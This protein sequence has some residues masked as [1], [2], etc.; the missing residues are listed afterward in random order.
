[1]RKTKYIYVII[2][3]ILITCNSNLFCQTYTI[4]GRVYT[5]ENTPLEYFHVIVLSHDSVFIKGGAF[6]NSSFEISE[7]S[8][9]NIIVKISFLGFETKYLST[10]FTDSKIIDFGD[11]FL[12][13]TPLELKEVQVT[14]K[15]TVII[16]KS[17][18]I[19][20]HNSDDIIN[21]SADVLQIL[22][23]VPTL[24]FDFNEKI[25]VIG[26]GE[27]SIYLDGRISSLSE[28]KLL[29]PKSIDKIEVISNP[30]AAYGNNTKSVIEIKT[31]KKKEGVFSRFGDVIDFTK[32]IGNTPSL[33]I[34]MNT[35]K[36]NAFV[37]YNLTLRNRTEAT[38][39]TNYNTRH[40]DSVLSFGSGVRSQFMHN[41]I[42][43]LDIT[44]GGNNLI[45][46]Q[47][48]YSNNKDKSNGIYYTDISKQGIR[49]YY[50]Y[51]SLSNRF[52]STN[53]LNL[54]YNFHIDS[55]NRKLNIYFDF[56]TY[57]LHSLD[58]LSN[59]IDG[60][61]ATNDISSLQIENKSTT[62][63]TTLRS[64]YTFTIP[65]FLELNSGCYLSHIQSEYLGLMNSG[66][67]TKYSENQ[68]ALYVVANKKIKKL[69]VS[70]GVRFEYLSKSTELNNGLNT[71]IFDDYMVYPS[72][73]LDYK[74]SDDFNAGISYTR[75]KLLPSFSNLNPE[76][77]IYDSLTSFQGNPDLK[78][79]FDNS[80]NINSSIFQKYFLTLSFEYKK[81]PIYVYS[82]YDK[83]HPEFIT[84]RP[85]NYPTSLAIGASFSTTQ[86]FFKI[87]NLTLNINYL[88]PINYLNLYNTDIIRSKSQI[89]IQVNSNVSIAKTI[90]TSLNYQYTGGGLTDIDLTKPYSSLAISVTGSF[91]HKS[92]FVQL[93][94]AD[95][96]N[97]EKY[98][99]LDLYGL[100]SYNFK[101]ETSYAKI[102][103]Y[104]SIGKVK[105]HF[106]SNKDANYDTRF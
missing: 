52:I 95:V 28:V 89:F 23:Q 42:L 22:K 49:D 97:R 66:S 5:K 68:I 87:W 7:I 90:N 45:K 56:I 57:A 51:R 63:I 72:I 8:E 60:Q 25:Q 14:A 99:S 77:I 98:Q 16:T 88:R 12:S 11:I 50:N 75:D 33:N 84:Y 27:P 70:G 36:I 82:D 59:F 39:E 92:L 10:N 91:F 103:L 4:K 41:L 15:R 20:F 53:Q 94:Y 64:D 34:S 106:S 62:K 18:R 24:I 78:P 69:S 67:D 44:P 93:T 76:K 58:K 37:L 61:P 55:L 2:I 105:T 80:I 13:Q 38:S 3:I 43:G 47:Y 101:N 96:F 26:K 32:T 1:M 100:R 73:S 17:D 65:R 31:K 19:I 48:F 81:N 40:T 9:N 74:L 79:T 86:T 35:K 29:D 104:W 21:S 54:Y 71:D 83:L 46:I 6:I 85:I 30:S 102:S